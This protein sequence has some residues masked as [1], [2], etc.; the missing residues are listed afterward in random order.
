MVNCPGRWFKLVLPLL[1]HNRS[2]FERA[3]RAAMSGLMDYLEAR[4]GSVA[5]Y[6]QGCGF[7]ATEQQ[8]LRA[9]LTC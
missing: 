5:G 1:P 9:F 4:H 3:P 6:L 8:R 7:S 2:V